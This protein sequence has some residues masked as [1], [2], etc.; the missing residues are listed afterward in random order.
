MN[1]VRLVFLL[2]NHAS[3]QF[4]PQTMDR[5]DMG[6]LLSVQR[7]RHTEFWAGASNIFP[8]WHVERHEVGENSSNISSK[9]SQRQ[10]TF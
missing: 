4:V 5:M 2:L 3:I 9:L 1:K 10:I 8:K 7:V 6:L